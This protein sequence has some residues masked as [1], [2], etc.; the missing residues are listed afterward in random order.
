MRVLYRLSVYCGHFKLRAQQSFFLVGKVLFYFLSVYFTNG[1]WAGKTFF[2][3]P[4]LG[5]AGKK[6][7]SEG[8]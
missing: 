6:W 7:V 5:G 1:I 3:F 4:W 2:S 8:E